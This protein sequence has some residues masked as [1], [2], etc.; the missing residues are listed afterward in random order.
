M[1]GYGAA[2]AVLP[3]SGLGV[4]VLANGDGAILTSVGNRVLELMTDG[5]PIVPAP[6]SVLKLPVTPDFPPSL[7]S[8]AYVGTFTNPRRFTVEIVKQGDQ[9]VLKRFGR[10]FPMRPIDMA[11]FR[12]DGVSGGEETIVIGL[13]SRQRADY[14]QMYQWALARKR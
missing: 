4:A 12:V 10:D 11:R 1:T 9:L 7:S 13:D 8:D 2:M 3:A 14:I 5:R 6:T